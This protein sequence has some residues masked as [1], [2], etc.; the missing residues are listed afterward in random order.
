MVY[1]V[2]VLIFGYMIHFQKIYA[3][4]NNILSKMKW[5]CLETVPETANTQSKRG[6][7]RKESPI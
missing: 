2:W 5:L 7:L 3:D 4:I 6:I 1:L